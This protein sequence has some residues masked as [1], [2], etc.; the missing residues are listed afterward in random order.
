MDAASQRSKV[1]QSVA[2]AARSQASQAQRK[3]ALPFITWI[4][5]EEDSAAAERERFVK[6]VQGSLCE[7]DEDEEQKTYTRSTKARYETMLTNQNAAMP[8]LTNAM[9]YRGPTVATHGPGRA[10]NFVVTNEH[11]SKA[12]NNGFSR[13]AEGRFYCH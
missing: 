11:H 12:T 7:D 1:T 5:A 6:L 3:C 10:P 2:S 8:K 4:A 9:E 13:G